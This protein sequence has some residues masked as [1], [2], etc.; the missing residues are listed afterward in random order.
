MAASSA[1]RSRRTTSAQIVD[2]RRVRPI[3]ARAFPLGTDYLGRDMLSRILYGAR[4]T[5]GVALR[6]DAARQRRRRAARHAGRGLSGALDR[7][8]AQPRAGRA[9]LASPA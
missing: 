4:Y 2:M 3:S 7:R 8:A 5:V 6:R 9:D 1:R